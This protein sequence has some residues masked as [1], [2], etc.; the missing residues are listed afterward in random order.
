MHPAINNTGLIL[1]K[2]FR[3]QNYQVLFLSFYLSLGLTSELIG[4]LIKVLFIQ[5]LVA[6]N[7]RD[8]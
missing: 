5:L 2:K 8:I 6:K 7:T 3:T 1:P 4:L